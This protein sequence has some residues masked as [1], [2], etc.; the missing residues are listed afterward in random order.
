MLFLLLPAASHEFLVFS[1]V[2][3][4]GFLSFTFF[5]AFFP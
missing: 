4:F 3:S 2:G 1:M 5:F